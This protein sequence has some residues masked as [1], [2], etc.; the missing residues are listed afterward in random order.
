M[1]GDNS[2]LVITQ[3]SL[4]YIG[5]GLGERCGRGSGNDIDANNGDEVEDSTSEDSTRRSTRKNQVRGS[6]R[7]ARER[8]AYGELEPAEV[9]CQDDLVC[10]QVGVDRK[11]CQPENEEGTSYK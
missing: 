10:M 7:G 3:V 8:K 9:Q 4:Y 6:V 2:S 11:E 1:I 5:P